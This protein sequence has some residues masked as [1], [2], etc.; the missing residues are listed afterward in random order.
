MS[1]PE[2]TPLVLASA[3]PRRRELLS[4]AGVPFIV[5]ASDVDENGPPGGSPQEQ[6]VALA[7]KKAARVAEDYPGRFVLGADTMVVVDERVLGKPADPEQARAMLKDLS[8]RSHVVVTG[9]CLLDGRAGETHRGFVSTE[10]WFKELSEDEIRWY[11]ET[12]E[13]FD[14]AGGYAIQGNGCF[15]VSRICGSY[16]NVVGLPM[17]ETLE[18]LEKSGAFSRNGA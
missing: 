7:E 10:V 2:K 16:T 3:S 4:S 1:R 9:F 18:I 14:K 15:M 6:A 12:G 11:L 5:A 13:P 8:G 17:A